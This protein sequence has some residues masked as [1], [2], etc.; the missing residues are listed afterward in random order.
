[1]TSPRRSS[2]LTATGNWLVERSRSQ[3]FSSSGCGHK[4]RPLPPIEQL[5]E[6]LS[7]DAERGRL[8]WVKR[9]HPKANLV[10]PGALA[11]SV[12][13]D[14]YRRISFAGTRHLEHR[15]IWAIVHG[16]DSPFQID[17]VN[18]D[19]FD[20]RI[21]NLREATQSQNM[22][23]RVISGKRVGSKKGAFYYKRHQ[24]WAANIGFNKKR[25]HLGYFQT[26]EEAHA[27]YRE[28]AL[29]LF[30]EFARVE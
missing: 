6:C 19:T 9:P 4:A 21:E 8:V 2:L 14:C 23:N 5:R 28:A 27:A 12:H 24:L 17:H 30:G 10:V 3:L 25:I 11:G 15:V 20:N 22:A 16:Y 18:G 1:M 29:R 13:G 26:E 7:Y